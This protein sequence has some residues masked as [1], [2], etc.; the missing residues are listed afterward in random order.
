MKFLRRCWA[1]LK[2]LASRKNKQTHR[3]KGSAQGIDNPTV[4]TSEFTEI[5]DEPT[6][7]GKALL[8]TAKDIRLEARRMA[9]ANLAN[10]PRMDQDSWTKLL[11]AETERMI[12]QVLNTAGTPGL[13]AA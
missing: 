3:P 10:T 6:G 2:S 7:V 1:G 9:K 8:L 11:A 5:A 12:R 4:T 13:C